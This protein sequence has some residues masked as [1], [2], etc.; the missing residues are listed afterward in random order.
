[1]L[2]VHVLHLGEKTPHLTEEFLS[3]L[4]FLLAYVEIQI[5]NEP[6]TI[7]RSKSSF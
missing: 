7:R 6:A 3:F 4:Q 2:V 5:W 1:V